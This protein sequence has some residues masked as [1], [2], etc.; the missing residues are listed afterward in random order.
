MNGSEQPDARADTE[1]VGGADSSASSVDGFPVGLARESDDNPLVH[2]GIAF[3][4]GLLLARLVSRRG[5]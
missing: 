3:L 2:I 1:F 5:D 4:G